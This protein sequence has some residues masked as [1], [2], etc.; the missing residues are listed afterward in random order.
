M[1]HLALISALT[2]ASAALGQIVP[3]IDYA[4]ISSGGHFVANPLSA[5]Q[6]CADLTLSTLSASVDGGS[7]G[8]SLWPVDPLNPSS[9][10]GPAVDAGFTS[11]TAGGVALCGSSGAGAWAISWSVAGYGATWGG[12]TLS[13]AGT[14]APGVP[15]PTGPTDGWTCLVAT[16]DAGICDSLDGVTIAGPTGAVEGSFS[17]SGLA[18]P[19][20]A[21]AGCMSLGGGGIG[22]CNGASITDTGP[23]GNIVLAPVD[24]GVVEIAGSETISGCQVF[25]NDAGVCASPSDV[26]VASPTGW[27]EASFQ[28]GNDRTIETIY[29]PPD[30]GNNAMNMQLVFGPDY[31]NLS[32]NALYI[33]NP[34]YSSAAARVYF[35]GTPSG[36]TSPSDFYAV[37]WAGVSNW[38][39]TPILIQTKQG[40]DQNF[41]S[42]GRDC[43]ILTSSASANGQ[44]IILAQGEITSGNGDN[45]ITGYQGGSSFSLAAMRWLGFKSWAED[46]DTVPIAP[47]ASFLWDTEYANSTTPNTV[48]REDGG[49]IGTLGAHGAVSFVGSAT[50]SGL[51]STPL[52][53]PAAPTL[54]T[55]GTAGSTTYY[56]CE[57]ASTVEGEGLCGATGA[58][59]TGN[60]T[61]SG[62]NYNTVTT[63]SVAGAASYSVYR[64]SGTPCSASNTW[65]V[66]GCSGL[67]AGAVCNDQGAAYGGASVSVD[68]SGAATVSELTVGQSGT[69][70][71]VMKAGQATSGA[72][73]IDCGGP[74]SPDSS[75]E[76]AFFAKGAP[77]VSQCFMNPTASGLEFGCVG[78]A[79]AHIGFEASGDQEGSTPG[80]YLADGGQLDVSALPGQNGAL[81]V[82]T[83]DKCIWNT[84]GLS[85]T[86]ITPGIGNNS[87][88]I[89]GHHQATVFWN[90]GAVANTSSGQGI[91]STAG[92]TL[93]SAPWPTP[94]CICQNL[95][96]YGYGTCPDGGATGSLY[97]VRPTDACSCSLLS[98]TTD[99]GTAPGNRG[100]FATVD[101]GYPVATE[102]S[103][104][105]QNDYGA[106]TAVGTNVTMAC[107][108]WS[109]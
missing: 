12:V 67:A 101:P 6:V 68:G 104:E 44:D 100:F 84:T 87:T 48:W 40:S 4:S 74:S 54:A 17:P 7:F 62:T 13:L 97:G 103:V 92:D 15:G 59:T 70:S 58:L 9:A 22:F 27:P 41:C 28:Q 42:P 81:A 78:A 49:V 16:N 21:I 80:L 77:G 11:P 47:P 18:T 53:T 26:T 82:G 8:L 5:S 61:L 69:D 3:V 10:V 19:E 90:Y 51:D 55:V 23:G 1:R 57:S 30:A 56:Y 64:C 36:N 71:L 93:C 109:M 72:S 83:S 25:A 96:P 45:W 73:I 79:G 85:C 50:V 46:S 38:E 75:V 52:A 63:V 34:Y 102:M 66:S 94:P 76:C 88:A 29:A 106:S 60:A 105:L 98:I 107:G 35:G 37:N 20:A 33:H 43:S 65:L 99:G 24:G 2:L 89:N 32:V 91:F 39:G 31:Q 14:A 95:S 86:A 108:C